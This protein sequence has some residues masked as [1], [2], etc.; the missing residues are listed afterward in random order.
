MRQVLAKSIGLDKSCNKVLLECGLDLQLGCFC[1][2]SF[3]FKPNYGKWSIDYD[4]EFVYKVSEW[5]ARCEYVAKQK[6]FMSLN[7]YSLLY[8]GSDEYLKIIYYDAD[9][10]VEEL[11][12]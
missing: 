6:E 5:G 1:G 9:R 7:G 4:D 2:Y 10:I 11:L 12:K 8:I 3:T